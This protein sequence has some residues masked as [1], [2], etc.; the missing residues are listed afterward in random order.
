MATPV[1]IA[2]YRLSLHVLM[3]TLL[4]SGYSAVHLPKAHSHDHSAIRLDNQRTLPTIKVRSSRNRGYSYSFL[5]LHMGDDGSGR[6]DLIRYIDNQ[7]Y[8]EHLCSETE[9]VDTCEKL[10]TMY[11]NSNLCVLI[12]GTLTVTGTRPTSYVR[13]DRYKIKPGK[14]VYYSS[15]KDDEKESEREELEKKCKKELNHLFTPKDDFP[16]ASALG[17]DL[18]VPSNKP[19][20]KEMETINKHI[21]QL[22]NITKPIMT[23][24]IKEHNGGKPVDFENGQEA[25]NGIYIDKNQVI[26]RGKHLEFGPLYD[27]IVPLNFEKDDKFH[28]SSY[29]FVANFHTHPTS[30]Y[31]WPSPHDVYSHLNYIRDGKYNEKTLLAIGFRSKKSYQILV[32]QIDYNDKL[33][34][35]TFDLML[36]Y[37][38]PNFHSKY[39]KFLK[40]LFEKSEMIIIDA[41]ENINYLDFFKNNAKNKQIRESKFLPDS[42]KHLLEE[43]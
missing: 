25:S 33:Y 34:Q 15:P 2:T 36:L 23:T 18:T 22:V 7:A 1:I 4:V 27:A 38:Q 3:L 21:N 35:E 29:K 10:C 17:I 30:V 14:V 32:M 8:L 42:C 20:E 13:F 39:G 31:V 24:G 12:F 16:F 6:L 40:T 41:E 5:S 9:D 26:S 28:N 11:P 37:G 19:I 43:I